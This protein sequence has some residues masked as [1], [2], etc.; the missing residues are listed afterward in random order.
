M[1]SITSTALAFLL[2]GSLS[3]SAYEIQD[4]EQIQESL[5]ERIETKEQTPD[6]EETYGFILNGDTS[7]LHRRNV[8]LG[9]Q[10]MQ[11]RGIPAENIYILTVPDN[12]SYSDLKGAIVG[13]SQKKEVEEIFMRKF[14]DLVDET[15]TAVIYLTGHGYQASDETI[16]VMLSGVRLPA[17][18]YAQIID[19]MDAK[20][21]ISV[22]DTCYSGAFIEPLKEIDDFYSAISSTQGAQKTH[23]EAFAQ[24]MWTS[25]SDYSL[26]TNNDGSISFEEVFPA[27]EEAHR[28]HITRSYPCFNG[29][30][31][32]QT[33]RD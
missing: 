10:G 1:K 5:E 31:Q 33:N 14:S 24:S 22:V 13:P 25:F 28:D 15:D 20:Q 3:V 9:Y 19:N 26:D 18:H 29:N 21:T 17:E 30:A 32:Y 4:L 7:A 8:S 12:G 16:D 23:C 2:A 11:D 27:V 6:R